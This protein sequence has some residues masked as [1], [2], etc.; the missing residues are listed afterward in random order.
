MHRPVVLRLRPAAWVLG[1][2]LGFGLTLASAQDAAPKPDSPE[3]SAPGET[4]LICA[5]TGNCVNSLGAGELAPMRHEG[6]ADEAYARVLGLL[7]TM[8]HVEVTRAG[9]LEVHAIF[10]TLLGFRDEVIF[11]VDPSGKRVDFRS[12]SLVGLHDFGKNSARM[13]DFARRFENRP[14][15]P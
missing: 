2:L 6:S 4:K 7:K 13:K 9:R 5:S 1:L 15:A 11:V 8:S 14:S 12:R 10:T 3:R